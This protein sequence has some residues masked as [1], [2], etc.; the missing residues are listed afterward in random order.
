[1]HFE[2]LGWKIL[3]KWK[4]PILKKFNCTTLGNP[5]SWE[6]Q[7]E[8]HK[9]EPLMKTNI[10]SSNWKSW[11]HLVDV[12][13]ERTDQSNSQLPP[14]LTRQ[15]KADKLHT[16]LAHDRPTKAA[17]VTSVPNTEFVATV[18]AEWYILIIDPRHNRLLYSC[19]WGN[20]QKNPP[21][22]KHEIHLSVGVK[23][24]QS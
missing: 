18:W 15:R 9:Q 3:Q 7:L 14:V 13:K 21:L 5:V 16:L 11:T 10:R 17:V 22:N 4:M 23:H 20:T 19:S 8:N 1:M 24:Q 2:L 12:L 6:C